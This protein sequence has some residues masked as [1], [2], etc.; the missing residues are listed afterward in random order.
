MHFQDQCQPGENEALVRI[1]DAPQIAAK[2]DGWLG[3][4]KKPPWGLPYLN[5]S[6]GIDLMGY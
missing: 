4:N 3:N 5:Y 1:P 2:S 6:M